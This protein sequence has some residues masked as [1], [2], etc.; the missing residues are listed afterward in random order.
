MKGKKGQSHNYPS[1]TKGNPVAKCAP[2][3]PSRSHHH[4]YHRE[5]TGVGYRTKTIGG[6]IGRFSRYHL[7]LWRRVSALPDPIPRKEE[8]AGC[9][10]TFPKACGNK[11]YHED[12]LCVSFECDSLSEELE[13]RRRR[14]KD[15]LRIFIFGWAALV[16]F[17]M[18]TC[19][20][21]VCLVRIK[22]CAE[23]INSDSG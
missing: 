15:S 14:K 12:T 13:R 5:K 2:L 9:P 19:V 4:C 16:C 10:G 7:L 6:E 17:G 8:W 21:S 18:V 22:G 1:T 23:D 11:G 3:Q 20:G